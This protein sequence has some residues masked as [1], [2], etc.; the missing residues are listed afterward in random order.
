MAIS[1][2]ALVAAVCHWPDRKPVAVQ[3]TAVTLAGG[4]AGLEPVR[5]TRGVIRGAA[6]RLAPWREGTP[7][8]LVEGIEDGLAVLRVE[9][10]ATVW[11]CAATR[12]IW[13][14]QR[15]PL[16]SKLRRA[17]RL[18]AVAVAFRSSAARAIPTADPV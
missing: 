4:K 6:T 11:V 14:R 9:A 12:T 3:L 18:P 2:R 5:W 1:V 8:I 16:S 13:L 15:A 17:D 7:I 10:D